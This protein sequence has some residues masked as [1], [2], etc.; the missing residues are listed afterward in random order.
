M[1][2]PPLVP[3]MDLEDEELNAAYNRARLQ[4]GSEYDNYVRLKREREEWSHEGSANLEDGA[5]SV[6]GTWKKFSCHVPP[7]RHLENGLAEQ[8][9]W[10]NAISQK[11]GPGEWGVHMASF[12]WPRNQDL[13]TEEVHIRP[14]A[15]CRKADTL[16]DQNVTTQRKKKWFL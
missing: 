1:G 10:L 8:I 11:N 2:A 14:N 16:V 6:G 9:D 13:R 15:G 3:P 12:L 4:G 7:Q 5:D